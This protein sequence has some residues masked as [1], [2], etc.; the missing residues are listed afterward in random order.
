MNRPYEYRGILLALQRQKDSAKMYI[1]DIEEV[2]N[3]S[4]DE[5]FKAALYKTLSIIK[6]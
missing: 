2:M 5:T 6:K 3:N 1:T 4:D